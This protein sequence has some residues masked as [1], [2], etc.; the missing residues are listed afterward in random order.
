MLNLS[1]LFHTTE[2]NEPCLHS[3]LDLT[4]SEREDILEAK[5]DVRLALKANMPRIYKEEGHEGAAPTPRFFTQ[6]SS[7]YKTLNAPAKP[8]Q[9]ADIDDGCY[10]PLSYLSQTKR[11]SV[12][13]GVFFDVAEKALTPLCNERGWGLSRKPT[14]LR[15]QINKRDRCCRGC[16]TSVRTLRRAARGN[17]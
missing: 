10:L 8:P 15:V 3:N 9:Q 12:A 5:K 14:C 6:G 4:A 1:P 11:P 13:V 16:C 17:P 2:E 7:A